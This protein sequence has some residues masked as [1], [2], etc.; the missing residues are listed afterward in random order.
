MYH[1]YGS[2]HQLAHEEMVTRRA[3]AE[4]HRL[5]RQVPRRP[6]HSRSA[7]HPARSHAAVPQRWY[8]ALFPRG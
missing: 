7:S 2:T 6:R 5:R 3:E 8:L 4:A 1:D